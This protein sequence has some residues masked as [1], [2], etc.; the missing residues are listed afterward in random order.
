VNSIWIVGREFFYK[1]EPWNFPKYIFK[2]NSALT[3]RNQ[4]S[5]SVSFKMPST[6][7]RPPYDL[8]LAPALAVMNFT[9]TLTLDLL[10]FV[11]E[12]SAPTSHQA[13]AGRMVSHEQRTI[14]GPGGDIILSIIRSS[15]AT[16]PSSGNGHPGILYTHGGGMIGGNR[17]LGIGTILDWVEEHNAVCVSVEY[18]LPPQHPDPAPVDDC[19]AALLWVYENLDNLRIYPDKLLIA[20]SSAGG[21]IAAG[22]ALLSR[23]RGGPRLCGQVL[24]CPMLDDRNDTISSHQYVEEGSWSRGS[25][26]FGWTCLLGDR[27]GGDQV[28]IYAAP[29]RATDLSGLPPAFIDVGSA[30]VFRDEAVN[31]ASL[32]WKFG[33]QAE[34]H[35]WAGGFHG[36]DLLVP[37]AELSIVAREVRSKWVRRIFS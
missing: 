37:N 34:L 2:T 20:G 35:V 9:P 25:N 26:L 32:L 5:Q 28:S 12:K 23:D 13:L 19:Y 11:R 22:T 4:F 8:E 29:A 14:A 27:R 1:D 33:V 15:V 7:P 31:Y 6:M 16:E 18:R 21:G 36:F 24:I 3:Y 10:D 30:E 17:F